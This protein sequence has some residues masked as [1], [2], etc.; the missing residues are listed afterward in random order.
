[1]PISAHNKTKNQALATSAAKDAQAAV[2]AAATAR[3]TATRAEKKAVLKLA[4]AKNAARASSRKRLRTMVS[5]H[6]DPEAIDSIKL[7]ADERRATDSEIVRE[8]IRLGIVLLQEKR[9]EPFGGFIESQRQ[10]VL[11]IQ[12][13]V[14][15]DTLDVASMKLLVEDGHHKLAAIARESLNLG[16]KILLNGLKNGR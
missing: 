10:D 8:A 12:K 14:Y 11:R 5:A 15:V 13:S 7:V 16:L 9:S 3:A 2:K 1:M 4:A 6:F